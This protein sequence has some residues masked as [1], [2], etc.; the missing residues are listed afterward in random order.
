MIW[1]KEVI[2][3]DTQEERTALKV[4][5]MKQGYKFCHAI[6]NK[7]GK[8]EYK[9]AKMENGTRTEVTITHV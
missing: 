4:T 5:L 3:K 6:K 2:L 7:K 9:I 1:K 8:Q